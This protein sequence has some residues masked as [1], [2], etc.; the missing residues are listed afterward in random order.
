[1]TLLAQIVIIFIGGF[2]GMKVADHV[3]P[4]FLTGLVAGAMVLLVGD[5]KIKRKDE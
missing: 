3:I 5:V 1:M 4:A 2:V